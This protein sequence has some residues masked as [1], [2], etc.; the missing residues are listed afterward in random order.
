MEYYILLIGECKIDGKKCFSLLETTVL[1]KIFRERRKWQELIEDGLLHCLFHLL[2]HL[3]S[4]PG[5]VPPLGPL[6]VAVFCSTMLLGRESA[7]PPYFE[8][9]KVGVWEGAEENKQQGN[10]YLQAFPNQ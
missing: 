8:F 2:L 6:T 10:S 1:K 4:H 9:Y 3:A 5:C 7:F